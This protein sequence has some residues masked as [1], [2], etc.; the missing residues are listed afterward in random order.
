MASYCLIW[1]YN[2]VS[3]VACA[4]TSSASP[5]QDAKTKKQQ[6]NYKEN[7]LHFIVN[8]SV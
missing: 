2:T 8:L 7:K 3:P 1:K 5:K 6:K 4:G